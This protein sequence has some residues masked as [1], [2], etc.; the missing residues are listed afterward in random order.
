MVARKLPTIAPSNAPDAPPIQGLAS[1]RPERCE[2]IS[3]RIALG[4]RPAVRRRKP[5]ARGLAPDCKSS[6]SRSAA[7]LVA[8]Q[9]L[10]GDLAGRTEAGR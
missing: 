7:G 6:A 4:G 3:Q 5:F 10:A 2:E 8:G 9:R 1:H